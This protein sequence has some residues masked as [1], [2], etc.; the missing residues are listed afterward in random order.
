MKK[1]GKGYRKRR[2][3]G[4]SQVR[5]HVGDM[6]ARR[7]RKQHGHHKLVIALEMQALQWESEHFIALS[8]EV[9]DWLTSTIAMEL[10]KDGAMLTVLSTL[11]AA[12]A[13]PAS[14]LTAT[15]F[16]DSQWAIELDRSD[17]AGKL[18]ADVLWKGLQGNRPVTLIVIFKCL[19][20]LAE[21]EESHA[22][23]L[24]ERVV[25][26]GAP[27]SNGDENW[28]SARKQ[29]WLIGKEGL[30]HEFT[31][32]KQKPAGCLEEQGSGNISLRLPLPSN[33]F[34]ASYVWIIKLGKRLPFLYMNE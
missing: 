11:L 3:H 1:R 24:V 19:L 32:Q 29:W 33:S 12:L 6:V 16:I 15:H 22:A 20:S 26:L 4:T 8:T 23:G 27:I 9:Q 18:L 10:L 7:Y 5:H 13:L 28:K 14:L 25:L 34:S 31:A 17:Q 30:K 21:V 2:R